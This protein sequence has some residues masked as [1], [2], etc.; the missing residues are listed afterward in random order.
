MCVFDIEMWIFFKQQ[1][2]GECVDFFQSRIGTVDLARNNLTKVDFQM[3]A[4]LQFIDTIDLSENQIGEVG[5]EAFK[6]LFQTRI[7]ISH[8]LVEEIGDGVFRACDNMT[9]LDLSYNKLR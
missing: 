1:L 7:N 3:F 2:L 9:F 5:R 4:D 8:N 6:N